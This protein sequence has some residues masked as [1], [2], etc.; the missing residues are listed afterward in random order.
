MITVDRVYVLEFRAYRY[1][2]KGHNLEFLPDK[3]LYDGKLKKKKFAVFKYGGV[4]EN[5]TVI[6]TIKV[7]YQSD[8]DAESNK[9]KLE[10][11]ACSLIE[12][13]LIGI[14]TNMV[15]YMECDIFQ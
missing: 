3:S 9:H 11:F 7:W 4:I 13:E 12:D 2:K 6:L 14:V 8:L 1:D 10:E 15:N 5:F